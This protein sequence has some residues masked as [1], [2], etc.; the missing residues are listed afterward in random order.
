MDEN[1]GILYNIFF[2]EACNIR[3][4]NLHTQSWF[5]ESRTSRPSCYNHMPHGQLLMAINEH[6]L[7]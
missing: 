3:T 5:I 2:N 6:G 1:G 4:R 7:E